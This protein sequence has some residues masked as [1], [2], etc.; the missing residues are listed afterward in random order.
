MAQLKPR[1]GSWYARVRYYEN[2]NEREKQIPLRTK[3][4]VT[5]HERI[6]EV[7]KVEKDIKALE[8]KFQT[9]STT[10]QKTTHLK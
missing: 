3:S 10:G 8:K 9:A 7:N 5:A 1:G 2:G 4:K 6:A